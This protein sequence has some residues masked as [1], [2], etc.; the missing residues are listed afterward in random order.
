MGELFNYHGENLQTGYIFLI[1]LIVIKISLN[2][3]F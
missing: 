2:L 3:S 1:K